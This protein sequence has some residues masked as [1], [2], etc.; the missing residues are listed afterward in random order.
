VIRTAIALTGEVPADQVV[1][2]AV[3]EADLGLR[4]T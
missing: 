2:E 3:A 4:D 1:L